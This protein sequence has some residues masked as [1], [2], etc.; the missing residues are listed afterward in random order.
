[1]TFYNTSTEGGLIVLNDPIDP[2]A[3]DVTPFHH[4]NM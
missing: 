1:M 4:E 3:V 2:K